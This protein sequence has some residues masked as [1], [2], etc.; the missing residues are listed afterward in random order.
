MERDLRYSLGMKTS[1][2]CTFIRRWSVVA[3]LL[4]VA[5]PAA[6]SANNGNNNNGGNNNNNSTPTTPRYVDPVNGYL[7]LYD[8][9]HDGKLEADELKRMSVLDPASYAQAMAFADS[10]GELGIDEL[11]AWRTFLKAQYLQK[12]QNKSNQG[13]GGG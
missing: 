6:F 2:H 3:A 8:T 5:V 7:S 10:R 9:N 4:L 1:P 12:Q 11:N 13:G